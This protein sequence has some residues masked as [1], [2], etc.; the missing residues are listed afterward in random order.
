MEG[1]RADIGQR[2]FILEL[3]MREEIRRKTNFLPSVW[4]FRCYYRDFNL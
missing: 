2:G 3:E 4:N 1:D